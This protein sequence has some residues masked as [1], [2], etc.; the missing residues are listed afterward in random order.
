M[1]GKRRARPLNSTVRHHYY[2]NSTMNC[3]FKAGDS[4]RYTPSVRGIALDVMS[5]PDQQLVVGS[6]YLIESVQD[7]SYVVVVGYDHPG[8]G[9][10]WSEFSRA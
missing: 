9:I 10:H 3:P 4:V 5:S 6:T 2:P 1:R 8:G 7:S